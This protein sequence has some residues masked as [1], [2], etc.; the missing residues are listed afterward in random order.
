MDPARAVAIEDSIHGITAANDAGMA[1]VA[2]P[3]RLTV[4]MDFSHADLVVRSCADLTPGGLA[5]LTASIVPTVRPRGG[6]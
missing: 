3:S 4:G 1:S 2:V 6:S 5:D